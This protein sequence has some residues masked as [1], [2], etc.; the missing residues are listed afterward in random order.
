MAATVTWDTL[1]ELA[2][3]RSHKGCAISLY[4]DLDPS[5]TPTAGDAETR[6]RSLL[7]DIEKEADSR[8][9]NGDRKQ[10]L[11]ADLDRIRGWWSDDFDRDGVRG[12]AIFA[13]SQT[14]S[15]VPCPFRRR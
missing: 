3:F 4:I 12:V 6:L 14:I 11:R 13:S 10:A 5:S 8:N 7:S 1:R 15:G 9:Y 2:G